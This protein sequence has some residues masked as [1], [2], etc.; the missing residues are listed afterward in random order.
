[1]SSSTLITLEMGLVIVLVL[2]FG[3]WE[4]YKLRRDKLK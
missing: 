3:F 1:M 2:G 4:L